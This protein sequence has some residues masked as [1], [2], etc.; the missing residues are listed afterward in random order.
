[1]PGRVVAPPLLHDKL[2]LTSSGNTSRFV[3]YGTRKE[4]LD[5]MR[6]R[7]NLVIEYHL[8]AD[9][10]PVA[11][12]HQTEIVI[13]LQ[14]L[15]DSEQTYVNYVKSFFVSDYASERVKVEIRPKLDSKDQDVMTMYRLVSRSGVK[16][17]EVVD[18]LDHYWHLPARTYYQQAVD[19][20][21]D[22][23]GPHHVLS[24]QGPSSIR[25]GTESSVQ[26]EPPKPTYT[27]DS[28]QD[29]GEKVTI[30]SA[31]SAAAAH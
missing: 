6:Q 20:Y 14:Y 1:M 3:F 21:N 15:H 13:D 23:P 8:F 9:G 19:M 4:I 12:Q 16:L 27:G 22:I 10:R 26:T 28:S 17:G 29:D 30:A 7:P 5:W 18:D 11:L 24:A 25:V 31:P 2:S